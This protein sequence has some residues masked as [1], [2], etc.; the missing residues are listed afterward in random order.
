MK[1]DIQRSLSSH[2]GDSEILL[3][4]NCHFASSFASMLTYY[5]AEGRGVQID[6]TIERLEKL[7]R[8][9]EKLGIDLSDL[10]LSQSQ[11]LRQKLAQD[12]HR[13]FKNLAKSPDQS[14]VL[15][16]IS[17]LIL[18]RK[19]EPTDHLQR[20]GQFGSAAVSFLIKILCSSQLYNPLF[21][22]FGLAPEL[23]AKCLGLIAD[24]RAI[25]HLFGRIGEV[26]FFMEDV[27]L[28]ALKK[29]GTASRDFLL[30]KLQAKPFS[31]EN[32]KAAF[33]LVHFRGDFVVAAA[34]FRL[35]TDEHTKDRSCFMNSLVLIC[36]GLAGT[37]LAAS[38]RQLQD[39]D[40]FPQLTRQDVRDVV[41]NWQG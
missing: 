5:R 13:F 8:I 21:P 25:P 23:A 30:Q 24:P 22:G 32:Q 3:H 18:S 34:G 39:D 1:F 4:R 26:G 40:T 20:V 41:Q 9:E 6:F 28:E 37:S 11:K 2:L 16:A 14:S 33:A 19:E 17:E 7:M 36:E 27:V 35:L 12:A 29:I 15:K 38:F 31:E 10:L